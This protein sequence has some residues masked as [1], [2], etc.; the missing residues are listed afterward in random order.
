LSA[1]LKNAMRWRGVAIL[2][3]VVALAAGL[4]QTS[5]GHAMLRMAGL[6]EAP[7]SYT[8][9]AFQRPQELS[10]QL[11]SKRANI[12]V[13]FVIHNV[14]G[15]TRDYQWSLLLTQAS[16]TRRMAAGSVRIA[17]GHGIAISRSV[18]IVCPRGRVRIAVSLVRPAEFIDAWMACSSSRK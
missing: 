3:V 4:A 5:P 9:L 14:G 10:E 2:L 6:L 13:A 1:V 18:N 7:T 11:R 8:S 16:R 12:A 15:A 17:S